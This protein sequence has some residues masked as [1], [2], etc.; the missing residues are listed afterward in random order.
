MGL[1]LDLTKAKDYQQERLAVNEQIIK[2]AKEDTEASGAAKLSIN[3]SNVNSV[4]ELTSEED[5]T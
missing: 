2:Q 5:T 1:G 3:I 4:R